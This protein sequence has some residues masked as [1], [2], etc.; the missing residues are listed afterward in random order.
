MT[1]I[2][3]ATL[4]TVRLGKAYLQPISLEILLKTEDH[5]LTIE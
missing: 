5:E 1:L 4:V 2:T 3:T